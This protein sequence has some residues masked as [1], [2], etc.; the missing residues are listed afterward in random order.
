MCHWRKFILPSFSKPIA[1]DSNHT[2]PTS[3]LQQAIHNPETAVEPLVVEMQ[4]FCERAKAE[5]LEK[6]GKT[7]T[8]EKKLRRN[9]KT[10]AES[11]AGVGSWKITFQGE[12]SPQGPGQRQARHCSRNRSE[13]IAPSAEPP[14]QRL[15]SWNTG[16]KCAVM[17]LPLWKTFIF[18][19][20][21]VTTGEEKKE[22]NIF[23]VVTE[24]TV[25][26]WSAIVLTCE[27]ARLYANTKSLAVIY[28]SKI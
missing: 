8:T 4:P 9:P 24:S 25:A 1:H 27:S 13:L 3:G 6:R 12:G 14:Q 26:S 18:V 28:L 10:T 2:G 17:A 19:N 23:S 7:T 5:H 21:I 16:D 20:I 15:Q 22:T 11:Q